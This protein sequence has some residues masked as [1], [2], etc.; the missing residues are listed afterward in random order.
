M[1]SRNADDYD[2]YLYYKRMIYETINEHEDAIWEY[3][4]EDN[5]SAI[6]MVH[7]NIY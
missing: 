3:L 2:R 5:T 1:N 4:K 7:I 6:V